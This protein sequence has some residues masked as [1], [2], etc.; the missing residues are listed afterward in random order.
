MLSG[1]DYTSLIFYVSGEVELSISDRGNGIQEPGGRRKKMR[2]SEQSE[3]SIAKVLSEEGVRGNDNEKKKMMEVHR[4]GTGSTNGCV[5]IFRIL[6][7]SFCAYYL[8][9]SGFTERI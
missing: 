8:E 4:G 3:F 9:V 6:Y 1:A 7:V 5:H 2:G